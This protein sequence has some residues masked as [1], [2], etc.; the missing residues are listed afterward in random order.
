M[1][2]LSSIMA[3]SLLVA[4]FVMGKNETMGTHARSLRW[5]QLSLL[6]ARPWASCLLATLGIVVMTVGLYVPVA[7]NEISYHADPV[8]VVRI[9]GT[10]TIANAG[11]VAPVILHPLP[12]PLVLGQVV[13]YAVITFGGLALL[14]LLWRPLSPRGNT[15]VRWLY[16]I[17]L[18]LLSLLAVARLPDVRQFLSQPLPGP[19]SETSTLEA[20]YLLP[21][22][23]VFPL[24]VLISCAAL[25][26]LRREP[27]PLAS[28]AQAPRT[29]WQWIAALTLTVGV[30]VWG[31]GFYLMPQVVTDAC[32]PVIFSVTQFAHG[33]CAGLDSDQVLTAASNAGLT[34]FA[35]VFVLSSGYTFLVAAGGITALGGWTRQLFVSTLAWLAI[36]PILAL[37]V[38]LVALQGVGVIAQR[39]FKLTF[40]TGENWHIASGMIVTFVGIGLVM[41]GQLGLW[42]E[43]VIHNR[44]RD[45]RMS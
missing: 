1:T 16:A 18:V 9:P 21:G 22:V 12:L 31:V 10:W 45:R 39:G 36:W 42:R 40:E 20:A 19:L 6:L 4:F 3:E 30:F 15:V 5:K 24:G 28:P 33:A 7:G 37:G 26:L 41:L 43:L 17:W 25:I 13:V 32:P 11:V 2:Q 44:S 35:R 34:P 8:T 27:R 23:V 14:P 38:A 29:T